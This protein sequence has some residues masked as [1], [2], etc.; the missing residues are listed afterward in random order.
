MLRAKILV[1]SD[2]SARGERADL[3]GPAVRDLLEGCGW[4]VA[5]IEI[6]PDD[7]ELIRRRLE[8][9]T[10]ADDCAA[11]LTTGGT[12]VGPR[13]VTPEA[14]R[15]VVE[16]EI[17]GLGELM[18]AHGRKSTPLASLSRGISGTRGSR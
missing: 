5:A 11:V 7:A 16:R 10:D 12:G 1:L 3:S 18:R 15:A 4:Q 14:T 17:P 13:D 2:A 6:L 9:L 8:I